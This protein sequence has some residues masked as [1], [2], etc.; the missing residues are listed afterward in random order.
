MVGVAVGVPFILASSAL[1]CDD[2]S[3]VC[4]IEDAVGCW[5]TDGTFAFN[6]CD[7]ASTSTSGDDATMGVG[8]DAGGA[9]PNIA[10]SAD[11]VLIVDAA[12]VADG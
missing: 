8:S 7:N 5:V 9:T 2:A 10:D 6:H 1:N 11:S 4:N 3:A 12:A